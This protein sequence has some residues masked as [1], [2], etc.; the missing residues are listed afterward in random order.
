MARTRTRPVPRWQ[1]RMAAA[2]TPEERLAVT[3]DRLRAALRHMARPR[4]EPGAQA[5]G[6]AAAAAMAARAEEYLTGLCEQ[7]GRSEG[8]HPQ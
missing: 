5:A 6:K 7:I 1:Q 3:C 2:V 4:R 8:G